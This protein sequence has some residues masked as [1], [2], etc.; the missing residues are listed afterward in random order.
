MAR[1]CRAT[2]GGKAPYGSTSWRRPWKTA[3]RA[4]PT[5]RA[6]TSGRE[7]RDATRGGGGWRGSAAPQ[8]AGRP[9]MD[10]RAGGDRGRPRREPVQR[11]APAQ[12]VENRATR[13][14]EGVDGAALPRH[15]GREGPLWI[16][17]LAATVEDRG[18][19]RS[20][21]TRQHKR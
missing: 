14:A 7:P 15:R 3:A 1:L 5:A 19:S 11:H 20:N 17:E 18:A 12:A 8:G 16:N 6:S 2:G 4:G 9:P 10:Q 13:R 21:G